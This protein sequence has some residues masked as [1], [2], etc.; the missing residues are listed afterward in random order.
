[1]TAAVAV[2]SPQPGSSRPRWQR[3]QLVESVAGVLA[4]CSPGGWEIQPS[5]A[6]AGLALHGEILPLGLMGEPIHD[7]E[8]KSRARGAILGGVERLKNLHDCFRRYA[9]T[10]ICELDQDI[11]TSRNPANTLQRVGSKPAV[12]GVIMS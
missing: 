6:V 2:R 3:S 11:I 4:R 7:T 9:D 12:R 10:G 5:P 1:M 8:T